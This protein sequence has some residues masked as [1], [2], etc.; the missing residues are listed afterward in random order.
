MRK[1]DRTRSCASWVLNM[2]DGEGEGVVG[3]VA[4]ERT[5][6]PGPLREYKASGGRRDARRLAD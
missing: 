4:W 1:D 3:A 2:V 5:G 6:P